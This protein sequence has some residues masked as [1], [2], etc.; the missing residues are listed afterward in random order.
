MITD[1]CNSIKNWF[2]KSDDD[3]HFGIFTIVDGVI[4]PSFDLK[5]NQY[6]RIIGSTFND[7]VHKFGDESDKLTDEEFEGAIWIMCV[8]KSFIDLVE[9]IKDYQSKYGTVTPF[10]SES[11]GGYSYSKRDDVTTWKDA[12]AIRLNAWRKML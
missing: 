6:F 4:T 10:N 8:P 1:V 7:G 12:F 9:E 5:T 11:F 2:V 3:K